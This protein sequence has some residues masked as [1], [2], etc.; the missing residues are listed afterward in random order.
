MHIS[1]SCLILL[2]DEAAG[3]L[4]EGSL[5]RAALVTCDD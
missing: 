5:D 3:K 1:D 4:G 2:G